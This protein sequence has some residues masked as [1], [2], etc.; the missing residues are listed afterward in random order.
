MKLLMVGM[1]LVGSLAVAAAEPVIQVFETTGRMTFTEVTTALTY[2]VEWTTNLSAGIWSSHAPGLASVLPMGGAALTVT[3]GVPYASCSYRVAATVATEPPPGLTNNFGLGNENWLIVNYPFRAH[4]MNP[5]TSASTHDASFG[6]PVGSVRV[7]DVY[8]ETG[9]ASPA[10]HLGNKILYYGG[11]LA[12]DIYIRYTDNKSYPAVVLNGGSM[13]L[14]FDTPS[15]PVDAWQH[16]TVPL[17]EGGWKVSGTDTNH[18]ATERDLRAVL[19]NLTGLYIYT[20]W[21]SGMD[22][23]NVDNITMT[24]P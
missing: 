24:P 1:A 5:T 18:V 20:E 8:Q 13:S 9:I 22:D 10:A 3:V 15:P 21:H 16:R 14:Y 11:Q 7:G 12:Y 23:T 4:V 19:Q 2:R 6:N 17:T